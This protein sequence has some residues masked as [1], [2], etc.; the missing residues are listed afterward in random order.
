[1]RL[2]TTEED[3]CFADGDESERKRT[4]AMPRLRLIGATPMLWWNGWR[5]IGA[6]CEARHV[7]AVVEGLET[8]RSCLRG[9][10]RDEDDDDGTAARRDEDDGDGSRRLRCAMRIRDGDFHG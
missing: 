1:M 2:G 3:W 7:D 6:V 9:A 4:P 10:R 5:Q 8:D